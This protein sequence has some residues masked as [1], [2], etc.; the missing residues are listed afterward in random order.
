ML[1]NLFNFNFLI[2]KNKMTLV[3]LFTHVLENKELI[4]KMKKI[5]S[6]GF[7][8]LSLLGFNSLFA[9]GRAEKLVTPEIERLKQENETLRAEINTLRN[10]L[11]NSALPVSGRE[12]LNEKTTN[13]SS[14]AIKVAPL[15][16]NDKQISDLTTNP[17]IISQR[18]KI[19]D[20]L[21]LSIG[22]R[23]WVNSWEKFMLSPDNTLVNV[24]KSDTTLTPIPT[25]S[26]R[27]KDFFLSGSYFVNSDY[28]WNLTAATDRGTTPVDIDG[29]RREFD[30]TAGYFLHP[31]LALTAGYK[32]I[33]QKF[34]SSVIGSIPNLTFKGPFLGLL[35]T[36]PI[37][38]G[39][40][41]YGNFAYGWLFGNAGG[42][43]GINSRDTEYILADGGLSYTYRF[44]AAGALPL[45]ASLFAGYRFQLLDVENIG[46]RHKNASDYTRGFVTGLSLAF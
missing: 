7:I 33:Q 6:V 20:D 31:N 15:A 30:I 27:Y 11:K 35:G 12:S 26:L 38:N 25:A 41:L 40:G 45:Y 13:E 1:L 17:Q 8:L 3:L 37:G 22:A 29:Q 43:A 24:A 4:R 42:F 18:Y 23:V 28:Q 10:Q 9:A 39:F 14:E 16:T 2:I 19:I 34:V 44:N 5:I 36:V 46:Q 32:D 21:H